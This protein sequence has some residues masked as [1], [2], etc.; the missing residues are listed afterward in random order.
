MS[1][2]LSPISYAS[3][4]V[5]FTSFALTVLIWVHAFWSGFQTVLSAPRE[6]PDAFSTLRQGLYEEREYL[7]QV[8]RRREG[9][10]DRDRDS[11]TKALYYEGGPTK[12]MNNALKDLIHDFKNYESPFLL[13]PHDGLEKEL[14]WSFDATQQAYRCDLWHRIL[15]LR[16]KGGRLQTR[17]IAVEATETRWMLG[18]CMGIMRECEGRLGAIERRLQM[19]QIG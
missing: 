15:W 6:I 11:K 3:S 14:E 5:G 2:Q 8:R 16:N 4:V 10:R 13:S 17:R 9:A 7:K 18:D 12:V 19:S 1:T